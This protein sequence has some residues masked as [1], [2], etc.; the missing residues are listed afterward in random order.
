MSRSNFF[1]RHSAVGNKKKKLA[2]F[3]FSVI[4]ILSG[5]LFVKLTPAD[6]IKISTSDIPITI[7]IYSDSSL[8][9]SFFTPAMMSASYDYKLVVR[10]NG[11]LGS[12]LLRRKFTFSN[13]GAP[14]HEYNVSVEDNG[15]T[16]AI[17]IDGDEMSAKTFTVS[18]KNTE[19]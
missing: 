5:V 10:E 7:R 11:P 1:L 14:L 18:I 12:V 3:F 6:C 2:I 19:E 15:D 16:A 8:A 9:D 4:V 17:I 13:D